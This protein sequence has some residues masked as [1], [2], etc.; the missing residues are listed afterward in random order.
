MATISSHNFYQRKKI[1]DKPKFTL[2]S[3]ACVAY[4][5]QLN[6]LSIDKTNDLIQHSINFLHYLFAFLTGNWVGPFLAIGAFAGALPFG[7]LADKVGRKWAT[8]AIGFPYILSWIS[9]ALAGNATMLYVGRLLAGVATG[10]SCVGK[11]YVLCN[12]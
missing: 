10:A 1:I 8:I 2:N 9:L 5:S 3:I 6:I 7:I 4:V 11:F 12:L